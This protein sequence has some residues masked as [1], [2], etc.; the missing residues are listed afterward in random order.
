MAPQASPQTSPS[1]PENLQEKIRILEEFVRQQMAKDKIPGLT[2]L[3]AGKVAVTLYPESS[4]ANG[5]WGLFVMLVK[6][7]A[8]GR[9][10]L[11]KVSGQDEEALPYFQKSLELNPDGFASAKILN[12]IANS[13]VTQGNRL[14]DA[15]ALLK[16][17]L[18]LHAKDANTYTSLGE[19]YARKEQKEAAL[20]NLKKA[21]ELDPSNERAKALLKKLSP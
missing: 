18:A 3:S 13:W 17:A 5:N 10:A 8:D 14:D 9:E 6:Q 15:I 11:K 2:I 1:I 7:T 16:I 19:I 21:I 20:E 4:R 12:Q